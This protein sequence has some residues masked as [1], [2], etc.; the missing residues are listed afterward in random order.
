[1]H[2]RMLRVRPL[3]YFGGGWQIVIGHMAPRARRRI[4]PTR[5]GSRCVTVGM[6]AKL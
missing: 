5:A 1:M 4:C 3:L 6:T 2:V